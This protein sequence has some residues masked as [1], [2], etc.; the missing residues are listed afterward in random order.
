VAGHRIG[1]QDVFL[2][3]AA[4]DVV[5]NQGDAL[6]GATVGDDADVV[7]VARQFPRDDIA[8]QVRDRPVFQRDLGADAGEEGPKVRHAAVVDIAVGSGQAPERGIVGEMRLHVAV[9][10]KL[11][12]D[13]PA[14]A[15]GADHDV[16]TDATVARHVATREGKFCVTRI[17]GHSHADLIAGSGCQA[18]RLGPRKGGRGDRQGQDQGQE[19]HGAN[20]ALFTRP[21]V[22]R[23]SR[24]RD[25][26]APF[27]RGR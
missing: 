22:V 5:Q 9:H 13:P 10:R 19:T 6:D 24:D 14:V 16:G 2:L 27:R 25:G 4:T 15:Q 8:G 17:V 26:L 11:Q 18:R 23:I 3:C 7:K 1:E 20:H 21:W 12:V